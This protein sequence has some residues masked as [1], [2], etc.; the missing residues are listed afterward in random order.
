M[1]PSNVAGRFPPVRYGDKGP[2][3]GRQDAAMNRLVGRSKMSVNPTTRKTKT[4]GKTPSTHGTSGGPDQGN[5]I[6]GR[7]PKYKY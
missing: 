5:F 4:K 1:G 7:N 2:T 3:R 6:L